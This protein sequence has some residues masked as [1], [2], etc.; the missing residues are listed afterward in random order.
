MLKIKF[1]NIGSIC[2]VY[3]VYQREDGK[4]YDVQIE[5]EGKVYH[6]HAE[7][8][9]FLWQ[10]N[11]EVKG[12]AG[13]ERNIDYVNETR[14]AVMKCMDKARSVEDFIARM[15]TLGYQTKWRER[16]TY[17]TSVSYTHLDVYKRQRIYLRS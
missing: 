8:I 12:D 14:T 9:E 16:G 4:K 17:I 15:M 10:E 7:N 6:C 5:E 11:D 3:S 13:E 1:K 2:P